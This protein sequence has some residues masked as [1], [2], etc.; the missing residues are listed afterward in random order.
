MNAAKHGFLVHKWIDRRKGGIIAAL[1]AFFFYRYEF[2]LV[3]G[4]GKIMSRCKYF[5]GG[6]FFYVVCFAA[7]W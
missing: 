1:P 5:I 4:N 3:P 6:K 7:G 2:R